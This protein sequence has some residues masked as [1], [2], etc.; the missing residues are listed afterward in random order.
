MTLGDP[1]LQNTQTIFKRGD[2]VKLT[3]Y[4]KSRSPHARVEFG[5]V[6]LVPKGGRSVWVLFD[7]NNRP[8]PV[9]RSYIEF[10]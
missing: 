2:R 1:P 7:G 6:A 8:T 4:G 5:T 10:A 3:E 9:H